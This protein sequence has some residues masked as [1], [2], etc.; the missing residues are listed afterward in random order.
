MRPVLARYRVTLAAA[1]GVLLTVAALQLAQERPTLAHAN[2]AL[3]DPAPN[4]VLEESP[5]RV[6]IQ[7]TEPLEPRFS[8]IRVQNADADMVNSPLP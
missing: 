3:A 4:S 5:K 6:V 2:L 7:F 8:E 1:L